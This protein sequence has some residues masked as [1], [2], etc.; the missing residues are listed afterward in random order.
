MNTAPQ[1][2]RRA[3]VAL[4]VIGAATIALTACGPADS[5][6]GGDS[7]ASDG[8]FTY[9]G[10]TQNTTIVGTLEALSADQCADANE[11]AALST[12]AIDGTTWDQQ[13]QVL[14]GN[15]A[16]SDMSMAGGTPSLMQEFIDADLV[17][18]LTEELEALGVS[19]RILPAAESTLTALY[20]DGDLYALP[21]EFNIEGFWYNTQ[22]LD[23][24]GVDVPTTWD[25]LA[26]AA[27]ALKAA[28]I[29]PFVAAG[30]DGWPVTRLVGDYIFR[31]LGADALQK[32]ADGEASL[33]DPEYVEA[34]EAVAEFGRQGY[35]GDAAGSIDYNTAMNQFLTGGGAFFYM[36]S[37]A[38]AN[39]N[40]PE[41]N[42]IG[43]ENIGF[44]PFPAVEGGA[45]SIDEVPANAGIPVMFTTGGWDDGSA[46]WLECV[47]QG[48][49]DVALNEFGQV[50]GFVVDNPPADQPALTTLVQDTIANAP[51]SVLWFEAKFSP[52]GTSVSQTN[53]GGLATGNLS[54]QEFME[55]VQAGNEG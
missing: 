32:V 37:W 55:L 54:G 12:D 9:L 50:T 52:E 13:L 53:G 46:A 27:A 42:Q 43:A 7:A 5:G 47:A 20:G 33:T 40:D 24:A 25:E 14:A 34:A 18:N 6:D 51:G 31:S 17:V 30:K 2:R 15:N 4:G 38:L 26:D 1:A 36:G 11:A 19:D 44:A 3:W 48:Y 8:E 29:Q 45:G 22:L 23:E 35:F 10:Q 21:T 41:Q 16:L 49:G 39:F 28:D